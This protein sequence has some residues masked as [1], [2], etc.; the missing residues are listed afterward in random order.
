VAD[1]S[2][3]RA[4]ATLG[5]GPHVELLER[6][7]TTRDRWAQLHG[8][9]VV[10]EEQ[11]LAPERPPSWSK[12]VLVRRLL[13]R[14]DDVL[15]IDA[16]AVLVNDGGDPADQLDRRHWLGLV[17]HRY[18]G[19][20]LPNFGVF[21]V[22]RC[23]GALRFLDDLWSAEHHIDHRWWENAALLELLGY[24]LGSE[25]PR[26]VRS[27]R[28]ERHVHDLDLGWNSIPYAQEADVPYVLHLAGLSQEERLVRI[29]DALERSPLHVSAGSGR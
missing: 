14:Y 27:T 15:W 17:T 2:R 23:R 19:R 11:L 21:V 8:Y 20:V 10:V 25:I 7:R 16:D 29:G 26:K 1:V 13:V 6:S 22:R 5:V 28:L 9:D 24:D 12:V 3:R 18:Q 4:L